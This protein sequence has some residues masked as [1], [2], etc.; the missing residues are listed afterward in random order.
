MINKQHLPSA[1]LA[2]AFLFVAAPALSADKEFVGDESEIESCIAEV[3]ERANYL[4]ANRVKHLVVRVRQTSHGYVL[5]IK[6]D[7]FTKSSDSAIRKYASTCVAKGDRKP[8]NFRISD[9]KV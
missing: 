3:N 9:I 2:S 7:V 4:G 5:K 8:I 6:T 1:L